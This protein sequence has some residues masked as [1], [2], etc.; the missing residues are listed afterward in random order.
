MFLLETS[1]EGVERLPNNLGSKE[2]VIIL[3]EPFSFLIPDYN[4]H[5]WNN[6]A[7]DSLALEDF[8]QVGCV[9]Y[10]QVMFEVNH[11]KK[12]HVKLTLLP[13]EDTRLY[14]EILFLMSVGKIRNSDIWKGRIGNLVYARSGINLVY[15]TLLGA[16]HRN[17]S[18]FRE[19]CHP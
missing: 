13:K 18:K 8:L 3:I 17:L 16:M 4:D 1:E 12:W 19:A 2:L 15:S 5:H 14:F 9:L 11:L 7:E 10:L 6:G